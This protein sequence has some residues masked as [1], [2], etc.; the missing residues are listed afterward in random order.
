MTQRFS[1]EETF[2]APCAALFA[3][4]T[5]PAF[6]EDKA[7][8]LG[9]LAATCTRA[10]A[11]GGAVVLTLVETRTPSWLAGESRTSF[12]TRWDP[13][14]LTGRWTLVVHGQEA[15]SRSSGTSRIAD[16]GA[17]RS[18]LHVGGEIEVR[19]PLLGG[20]IE[21]KVVAGITAGQVREAALI[22]RRLAA[23]R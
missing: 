11:P 13:A 1:A 10:D 5:D 20:A 16:A 14:A 9:A 15:R 21:R 12:V 23:A 2:D 19:V 17:G 3:L 6:Q 7:R 4:L 8:A 22:R 18:R